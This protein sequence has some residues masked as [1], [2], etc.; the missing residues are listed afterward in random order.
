MYY[1]VM[2]FQKAKTSLDKVHIDYVM[3]T[4]YKCLNHLIKH[5]A[6]L[7]ISMPYQMTV[8]YIIST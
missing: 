3:L 5:N 8:T 2:L 1:H 4:N 6:K 7:D